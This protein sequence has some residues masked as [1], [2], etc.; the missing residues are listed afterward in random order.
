MDPFRFIA[1]LGATAI[2]AAAGAHPLPAQTAAPGSLVH[3]PGEGVERCLVGDR[4]FA[5]TVVGGERGCLVPVGLTRT[6]DVIAE[7]DRDGQRERLHIGLGEYPYSVQRLEIKDRSR[8]D[9]S[10]ENL[11]RVQ[12]ENALIGKLWGRQGKPRFSLPLGAPL[13]EMPAGGRFGAKR[14]INGEPRSP[15][16]GADYAVPQGTP[17]LAVEDAVVAL[18]G[19]F[20]FS[21]NAVFLDHG[22]GLIS[23]Y[24]HLHEVFVEQGDQV[25]RGRLIGTVGSTG[26]STGPH[27]HFGI[28]WQGERVDP[29]LL[30][31]EPG[32]ISTVR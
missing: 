29:A 19:E 23:M 8:V 14:I 15:H 6:A 13:E 30:L 31:G 16:T 20:F 22:N 24:F 12:R 21:G 2:L 10:P 9:L 7:R 26:R 18:S 1:V 25:S 5:P 11:A 4:A 17:V 3:W 32:S 27:L 28:R